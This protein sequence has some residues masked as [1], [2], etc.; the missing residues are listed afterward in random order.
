MEPPDC[1]FAAAAEGWLE[2]N[3]PDEA[4]VELDRLSD[5]SRLH[6][7]ILELRWQILATLGR[8]AMAHRVAEELVRHH[9]EACAGWLHRSYALRRAP[10]G[11]LERAL[12][13]LRPAAELFPEEVTVAY[14]LACY[15]TQLGR[16]DE[17]WEWF[18]R[19]VQIAKAAPGL[20][21][22]AL[23]DADLEP[24]WDR[25]RRWYAGLA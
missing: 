12:E 1:H 2:L 8:W 22:M 24:L 4:L 17:G 10:D 25:V 9:P 16:L 15:Q 6:P 21:D 14:N 11:G 13:A 23:G 7:R 19:A 3:Q 20:R 18:L 5:E